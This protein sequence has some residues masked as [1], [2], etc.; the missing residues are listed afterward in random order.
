MKKTIIWP[1]RFT[2]LSSEEIDMQVL[3]CLIL[4]LLNKEK[5]EN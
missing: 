2:P 4:Y 3:N 5:N 1:I